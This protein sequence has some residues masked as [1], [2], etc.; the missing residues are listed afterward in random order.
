MRDR[1]DWLTAGLGFA[2]VVL[3]CIAGAQ[4]IALRSRG[5]QPD[6]GTVPEAIAAIGTVGALW[7]AALLWRHEVSVRRADEL[8]ARAAQEAQEAARKA[9]RA[10]QARLVILEMKYDEML[11]MQTGGKETF[12]AGIVSNLSTRPIFDVEIDVPSNRQIQLGTVNGDPFNTDR[13]RAID[14]RDKFVAGYEVTLSELDWKWIER[15]PRVRYTDANG[16]RWTRTPEGQPE[17]VI[18]DEPPA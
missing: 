2:T 17:E 7:V 4:A 13:T 9:A 14:A 1:R 11:D 8:A 6:L 18:P 3:A 5:W 15:V 16:V 12:M 10:D